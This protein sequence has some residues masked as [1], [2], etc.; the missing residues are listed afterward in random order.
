MHVETW[1]D[2]IADIAFIIYYPEL[3]YYEKNI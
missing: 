3:I 1:Y 2:I